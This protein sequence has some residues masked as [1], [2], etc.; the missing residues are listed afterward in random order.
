MGLN[1]VNYIID[2]TMATIFV[3][4]VLCSKEVEWLRNLIIKIPIWSI[5]M[6]P[7]SIHYDNE[8]TLSRVYKQ[9]NK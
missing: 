2:S 5:P 9:I 8:E 1:K 6:P 3:T 7:V 4:L